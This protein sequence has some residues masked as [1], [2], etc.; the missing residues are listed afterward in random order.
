[1]KQKL[2]RFISLICVLS[3]C[4]STATSSAGAYWA[5]LDRIEDMLLFIPYYGFGDTT[6]SHFNEALWEWN[7]AVGQ[8]LMR[9]DPT[10]R[11]YRTDYP[12]NDGE[13]LIYRVNT[14]TNDYVGQATRYTYGN[15]IVS[16][17]INLNMYYSWANGAGANVYD[18]WTVF[19]H[20]A[21]H[22]AGLSHS[23]IRNA[24]MYPTVS[25]NSTNR[26]LSNDDYTGIRVNYGLES[27]TASANAVQAMN[28]DDN[29]L[30]CYISGMLKQYGYDDLLDTATVVVRATVESQSDTFQISPV[31]GGD[32]S[33]F[34]DFTLRVTDSFQGD[35]QIGD[36]LTVRVQGGE[37]DGF[38]VVV[39]DAPSYQVGDD[40]LVFLYQPNLGAGYNTTGDYY[41]TLGLYQGAFFASEKSYSNDLKFEN[42]AGMEI[43]YNKISS[44]TAIQ[45]KTVINENQF[46]NE[47]LDNLNM[48]LESGFISQDEY[49]RLLAESQV[50]ATIVK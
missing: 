44:D 19:V 45:A 2:V 48:N 12:S 49:D 16:A 36:M 50:Y 17:D 4:I 47:F 13:N 11:H 22:A 6:I 33:N 37:V 27:A 25:T 28:S 10:V 5:T 31:S 42:A 18:V 34:T 26:Y 3:I 8:T 9:R 30:T 21:G 41:Y 46:Y 38:N 14:G 35:K 32:P 7:S 1:M 24:V 40:V 29:I 23:A 15:T 43:S 39:E 20:E